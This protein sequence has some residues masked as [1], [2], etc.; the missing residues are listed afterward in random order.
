LVLIV[1]CLVKQ[2]PGVD[3]ITAELLKADIETSV[4]KIYKMISGIWRGESP[5]G[6]EHRTDSQ[7]SKKG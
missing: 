7:A 5:R 3:N 2:A 4:D 6:L 1:R